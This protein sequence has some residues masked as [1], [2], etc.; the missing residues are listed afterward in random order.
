MNLIKVFFFSAM[1]IFATSPDINAQDAQDG[2]ALIG[3]WQPSHGKARIKIDKIAGKYYG[4][5]VWLREPIDPATGEPKLD[6]NNPDESMRK[7]PLRGYRMLK[8]F[9]Y[10]GDGAWENGTIYDPENGKTYSC[11]IKLKDENTL[12]IRGYIG[13]KTFGRTDEWKRLEMKK[14]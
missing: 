6:K 4:K 5:I 9:E 8:D 12:D 1:A 3:V 10:V 7:V 11:V 14:K 13:V 2:D